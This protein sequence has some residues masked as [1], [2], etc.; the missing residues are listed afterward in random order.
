[1][2]LEERVRKFMATNPT[3]EQIQNFWDKYCAKD[4]RSISEILIEGIYPRI[5][6]C[7]H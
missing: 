2:N 1:M 5:A 6:P 7:T 3:E 4:K